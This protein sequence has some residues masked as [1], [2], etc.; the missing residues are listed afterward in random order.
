[1]WSLENTFNIFSV[2]LAP[3]EF[4][5]GYTWRLFWRRL[6]R[7][8]CHISVT[9][10]ATPNPSAYSINHCLAVCVNFWVIFGHFGKEIFFSERL[11]W[12][13]YEMLKIWWIW[14]TEI[15]SEDLVHGHLNI[16]QYSCP[17]GALLSYFLRV[18]VYRAWKKKCMGVLVLCDISK[19]FSVRFKAVSNGLKRVPPSSPV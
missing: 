6:I 4:R 11:N 16:P 13:K 18:R 9:I 5:R 14:K 8:F 7:P 1:M 3:F 12:G 19:C 15:W 10:Q 2:R 17:S